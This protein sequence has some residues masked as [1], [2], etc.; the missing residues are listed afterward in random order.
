MKKNTE[1]YCARCMRLVQAVRQEHRVAVYGGYAAVADWYECPD[2][3]LRLPH[4]E[5]EAAGGE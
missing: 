4:P 2:C 5:A 3:G 1:I